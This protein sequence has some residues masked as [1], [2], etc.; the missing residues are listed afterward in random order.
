MWHVESSYLTRDQTED[1]CIGSAKPL[2]QQ[3]GAKSKYFRTTLNLV[4]QMVQN[5]PAMRETWVRS[6]GWA[7]SLVEG[8]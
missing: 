7:Q 1:P 3:G 6:L 8:T 2:D 4:T 5:A